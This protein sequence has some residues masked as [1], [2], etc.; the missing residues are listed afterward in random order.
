MMDVATYET[1]RNFTI[2]N[3]VLLFLIIPN[4]TAVQAENNYRKKNHFQTK[5]ML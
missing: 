4:K 1:L 5:P 2:L 3:K